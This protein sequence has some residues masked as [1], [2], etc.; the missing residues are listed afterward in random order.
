MDID[1]AAIVLTSRNGVRALAAW[2]ESQAWRT[3]PVFAVGAATAGE[4]ASVGFTRARSADGD[5][6]TLAAHV[7]N[8][9]APSAGAILYPAAEER[10]PVLEDTLRDAGYVIATAVAYRM[11]PAEALSELVATALRSDSLD[12]V[13]LYSR[14]TASIFVSLVERAGLVDRLRRLQMF[15]MS[16][17]VKSALGGYPVGGIE[18]AASPKEDAL[19][20]LVPAAC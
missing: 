5:G 3:K 9:I 7:K 20:N 11:V 19:L 12:G 14:R 13:L 8:T 6:A 10:S 17:A 15:V 1:P 2:P 4:A 16:E 18:V